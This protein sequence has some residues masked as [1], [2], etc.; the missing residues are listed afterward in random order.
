MK[1]ILLGLA[2]ASLI[3]VTGFAASAGEQSC[4]AC[5]GMEKTIVGPGFNQI[6]ARYKG[7]ADAV[8][9]LKISIVEG[10][11]GKWGSTPM[12]ANKDL[13]AEEV[14]RFARWVMSL[15]K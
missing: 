9:K 14:D 8:Q 1:R 5:H 7:D 15:N 4:R 13:T 11:S 3:P 10:S 2:I 12:P 6:A